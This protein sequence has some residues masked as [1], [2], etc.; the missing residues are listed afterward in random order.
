MEAD[1]NPDF[2]T[3]FGTILTGLKPGQTYSLDFYQA[4]SQQ[5]GFANGLNTT[6]QWI[7]GL[8]MVSQNFISTCNGCGPADA[9]MAGMT[10]R[11]PTRIRTKVSR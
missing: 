6:E 2:E 11:I 1:G 5:L 3:G 4:G 10:V 9:Y 7:V 8:G